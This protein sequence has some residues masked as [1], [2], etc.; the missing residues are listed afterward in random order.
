[1][2]W[3][4]PESLVGS[5]DQDA[6]LLLVTTN[7]AGRTLSLERD[8][9]GGGWTVLTKEWV[10]NT[11]PDQAEYSFPEDFS[12]I[13]DGTVW[14]RDT[15]RE[16]RGALGPNEWQQIKS[17]LIGSVTISPYYRIRRSTTGVP[18]LPMAGSHAERG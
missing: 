15:Y 4:S 9:F 6:R 12:D 14:D 7:N 10:F 8:V 3:H 18:P 5:V 11:V 13:V 1:M 16:A 17:S 2:A